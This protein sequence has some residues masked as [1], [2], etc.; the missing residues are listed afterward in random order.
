MQQAERLA[1]CVFLDKKSGKW[2]DRCLF[3]VLFG[4]IG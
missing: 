1:C 2:K 4:I 3:M